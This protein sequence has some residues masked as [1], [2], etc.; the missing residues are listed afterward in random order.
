MARHGLTDEQ[1]SYV[2]PLFAQH[3]TA[4]TGRPASDPRLMLEGVLWIL[5]TGAPWRDLPNEFG[6]W[7]TVYHH[8][9]K[10]RDD[11]TLQ[12]VQ[13]EIQRRLAELHL[14]DQSLWSVDGTSIRAHASAGGGGKKR[15]S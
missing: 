4:S 13:T 12:R 14:L 5:K 6:P 7:K 15:T 2:E 8:F 11:G 10:W 1:W 9:S 3:G